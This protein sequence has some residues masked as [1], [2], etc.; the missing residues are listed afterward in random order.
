MFI[1]S[2]LQRQRVDTSPTDWSSSAASSSSSTSPSPRQTSGWPAHSGS[3]SYWPACY[4]PSSLHFWSSL[5]ICCFKIFLL[6]DKLKLSRSFSFSFLLFLS[7]FP[8]LCLSCSFSL[9]LS[10]LIHPVNG[11]ILIY[12]S[13]YLSSHIGHP[14]GRDPAELGSFFYFFYCTYIVCTLLYLLSDKQSKMAGVLFEDIFDVKVIWTFWRYVYIFAFYYTL[15]IGFFERILL[16][17]KDQEMRP[18]L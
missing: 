16:S 7:S 4:Y 5:L 6:L 18:I 11:M 2:G 9:S 1:S 10:L 17:P 8:Y 12:L 14:H 13:L 3:L 15:K